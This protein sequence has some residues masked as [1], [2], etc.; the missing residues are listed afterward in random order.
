M[1]AEG[2]KNEATRSGY[3]CVDLPVEAVRFSPFTWTEPHMHMAKE[4]GCSIVFVYLFIQRK[5]SR[6][7]ELVKEILCQQYVLGRAISLH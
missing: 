7:L 6:I 3:S 4:P 2:R 5:M 1:E